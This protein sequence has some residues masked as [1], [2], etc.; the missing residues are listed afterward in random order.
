MKA[1]RITI[2]TLFTIFF[3]ICIGVHLVGLFTRYSD[4][5]VISHI[6]HTI[7]YSVCLLTLL[8]PL[9]LRTLLYS[10]AAVYPFLYH[11]NCAWVNYS[12]YGKLNPICILV[13]VMMPLCAL[14]IWKQNNLAA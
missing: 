5:P 9:R 11:A 7:S 8:K 2:T 4:E 14:W 1:T 10:S 12:V 13:V 6:V 3:L